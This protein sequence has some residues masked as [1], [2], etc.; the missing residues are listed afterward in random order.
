MS[1]GDDRFVDVA[2]VKTRYRTCG[3]G[4]P[5]VLVHGFG[6][7]LESWSAV[8][9]RLADQFEVYALDLPG[10]GES[11]TAQDYSLPSL[12]DVLV[13][14]LD[15]VGIE[16]A[17]LVGLSFGASVVTAAAGR[18]D[19][20]D[21][22]ALVAPAF[23]DGTVPLQFRL[24]LVPL[25][26]RRLFAASLP[27]DRAG[28]ERMARQVIHQPE[29]R[30]DAWI[31]R[32]LDMVTRP[33]RLDAL[34]AVLDANLTLWGRR[35]EAFAPVEAYLSTAE[36]PMLIFHGR[37]DQ[38]IPVAAARSLDATVEC[39]EVVLVDDCGHEVPHERSA[40]LAARL[41]A[42]LEGD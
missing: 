7:F 40:D 15:A 24:P 11:D 32:T 3:D 4:P 5:V 35:S 34:Y 22:V 39:S 9:P 23:V 1:S 29:H 6:G 8:A 28:V 16:R 19:R 25:I 17:H 21:R 42:F 10:H 2:G 20:V 26:G 30:T 13:T 37:E 36:E 38:V 31:E 41:V 18:S 14:F 27:S 33:G 12:A